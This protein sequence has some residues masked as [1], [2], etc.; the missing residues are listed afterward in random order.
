MSDTKNKR[1]V[2]CKLARTMSDLKAMPKSKSDGGAHQA[3]QALEG[4]IASQL[5]YDLIDDGEVAENRH[6]R[7]SLIM[8]GSQRLTD[9]LRKEVRYDTCLGSEEW[10]RLIKSST[11][12]RIFE[13]ID[14]NV[15]D[16]EG[17]I[18]PLLGRIANG[19][20]QWQYL[21]VDL[22][23][24]RSNYDHRILLMQARGLLTHKPNAP[25]TAAI[26]RAQIAVAPSKY[27]DL[28]KNFFAKSD[29]LGAMLIHLAGM[30]LERVKPVLSKTPIVKALF[31]EM[32]S[33]HGRMRIMSHCRSLE[34]LLTHAREFE[35]MR[36]SLARQ[37]GITLPRAA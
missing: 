37:A 15:L 26:L 3:Y 24:R 7:A 17:A 2:I 8:T 20:T 34:H 22:A 10:G 18:T 9:W 13:L 32:S 19:G 1:R 27:E 12:D 31:E 6:V 14:D 35:D 11:P 29:L 5:D 30:P 33:N 28:A 36:Q 21:A 25:V 23:G 4:I 16:P